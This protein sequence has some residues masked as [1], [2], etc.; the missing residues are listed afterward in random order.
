MDGIYDVYGKA[1]EKIIDHDIK[2]LLE[3]NPANKSL[4]LQVQQSD[5][6]FRVLVDEAK[7]DKINV[8]IS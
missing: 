5:T 2:K 8:N 7:T 6:Y 4:K 1:G 3:K